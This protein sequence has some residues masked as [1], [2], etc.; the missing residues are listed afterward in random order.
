MTSRLTGGGLASMHG[1]SPDIK[2]MGKWLG[3]GLAFGAFGGR[4]DIMASFDPR[5]SG[6]ISHSGTFNN[7]TLVTHAGYAGMTEVYT[8]Q[9]ADDFTEQ[10]DVFR[11]R[12]NEVTKGTR[13]CF[14][15]MGTVMA[16]HITESGARDISRVTDSEEIHDLVELFWYTMAEEGFWVTRRGMITVVLGTP[17]EELDRF[18]DAVKRFVAQNHRYLAIV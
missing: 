10:G 15:G 2:T 11:A 8:P 6:S 9:V 12:L 16:A 18:V 14:T 13:M 17:Q 3:G 7:N 1:L 5:V 4:A